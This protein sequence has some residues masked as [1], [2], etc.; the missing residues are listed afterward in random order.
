[1][2]IVLYPYSEKNERRDYSFAKEIST[3]ENGTI[4]Q[5]TTQSNRNEFYSAKSMQ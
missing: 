2:H 1:M 3:I 5:V 4:Y